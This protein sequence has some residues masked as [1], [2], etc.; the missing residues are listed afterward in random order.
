MS[1]TP[2]YPLLALGPDRYTGCASNERFYH[3]RDAAALT[4]ASREERACGARLKWDLID[5]EWQSF[6]ILREQPLRTLTPLWQR[7]LMTIFGQQSSIKDLLKVELGEQPAAPHD[8][9]RARV[10]ASILRNQ[11]EWTDE[12]AA[13]EGREPRPLGE[14]LSNAKAAIEAARSVEDLF[15][16]L[17]AA[18]PA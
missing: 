18:W 16:R 10:W 4:K 2:I 5:N 6:R 12:G 15:E 9:I 1:G 8:E 3:F 7:V 14:T 13:D 17:S 11:D